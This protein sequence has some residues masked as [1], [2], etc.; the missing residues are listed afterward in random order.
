MYIDVHCHLDMLENID[1]VIR[2]AI[3]NNV[4][5]IIANGVKPKSNRKVLELAN[6]YKEVKACIGIYPVDGLKMKEKE[7]NKEIEFIR[8]NKEKIIGIGEVGLDFKEDTRYHDKQKLVFQKFVDIALEL[9]L[10]LTVHSR[11]AE[12]ECIE[13]LEKAKVTK[14]IMH[15]FSG[16]LNLVD[17]IVRN[18]W[19]LSIPTSIKHNEH[20]QKLVE[21]APIKNLLCETDSPYSHP[22]KKFPN[23]PANVVE[24]YKKIAEIKSISLEE[25]EKKIEDN[26]VRLFW[27]V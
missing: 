26:F 7:I 23:E 25:V 17:R 11:N 21:K 9:N 16:K 3:E 14:V 12:Q 24:S 22:D 18:S 19:Y 10:P 20:F 5:I 13:M 8:K 2:R 1:G 4:K 6:K 15:Y 27:K